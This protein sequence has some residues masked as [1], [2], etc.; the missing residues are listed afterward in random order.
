MQNRE[1]KS[2]IVKSFSGL[3]LYNCSLVKATEA[4]FLALAGDYLFKVIL[5]LFN[6][7]AVSP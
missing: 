6:H 5:Q 1:I 2:D 3:Y 7:F 4:L